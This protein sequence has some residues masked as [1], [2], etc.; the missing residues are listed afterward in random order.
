MPQARFTFSP[1]FIWGSA[2][3]AHQV[4]GNN[5]NNNW[6]A[7]EQ[8]PE[9]II[10]GDKSGLA[11]DWWGGRWKE[12]LDRAAETHQ[13]SHRLSV[14][15]SR[16]Q[17]E[18]ERWDE[19]ALD[20]YRQMLQGV[21][22]RGLT[23]MVTLHHF[24]DPLWLSERGGWEN[25][26]TP[27]LFVAFVKK[28]VE[29]L[30]EYCHLWVTLN[31]PNGIVNLGYLLG[32]FPPGKGDLRLGFTVTRNLI[33]G[34]AAAYRAIHAIQKEAQVGVA[35]N[36]RPLTPLAKWNPLDRFLA[37]MTHQVANLAFPN[38]LH[39]GRLDFFFWKERIP[40]AAGTQDFFGLNYYTAGLIGF[41]LSP[42]TFW[43][44]QAFDKGAELSSTGFLANIPEQFF[45][46]MRWALRFKLP[47]YITENGVEDNGD[48]LRPRYM[49]QHIH[50]MWRAVTY[51]WPIKGYYY[52]SLVDNFE[53]ERGWTQR[54]GLWGLDPKTQLRQRR[55]SVDVYADICQH[56]AIRSE[57]VEQYTP[58]L[59][60]L[61]FPG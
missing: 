8:Q 49:I 35:F 37:R 13:N 40:E 5:T 30:Q 42:K 31:E 16:I 6:W 36:Y 19:D 18:P 10:N 46:S 3:A 11:C 24:T 28:V 32:V 57:M 4:E 33:R 15:W 58:R 23:P 39:D 17:P 27:A 41:A 34:H 22:E 29:A 12:D 54:F 14:E 20:Y 55:A 43:V 60:P 56:N 53:W 51:S 45:K 26:D 1:G 61:L 47:I 44:R 38:T 59:M 2:T 25:D 9:H 21:V 50:Q 7:W 48:D 52:W